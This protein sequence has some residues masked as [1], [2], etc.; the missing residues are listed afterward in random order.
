MLYD[1][2]LPYYCLGC[3]LG[4]Q[5]HANYI[6]ELLEGLVVQIQTRISRQ[7]QLLKL[8]GQIFRQGDLAQ[9]VAAQI[10]TLTTEAQV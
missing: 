7:V 8:G 3:T 6:L 9:F 5:K 1:V 4:Q 10:Y 2:I